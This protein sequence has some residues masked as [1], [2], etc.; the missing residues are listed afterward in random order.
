MILAL[1]QAAFLVDSGVTLKNIDLK[2]I[3]KT[4]PSASTLKEFVIDSATDSAFQAWDEVVQH[5]CKLFLLCD[6]GAKKTANAHFV[7]ILST[8]DKKIRTFN[9]DSN[10]TDGT[11]MAC[12]HA[13]QHALSQIFGGQDNI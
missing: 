2:K 7:K 9:M 1:N 8:L 4:A 11:S 10:D 5:N 12:A 6:E 13:I 3:A